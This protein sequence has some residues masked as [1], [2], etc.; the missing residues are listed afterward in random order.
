MES[1]SETPEQEGHGFQGKPSSSC[2]TLLDPDSMLPRLGKR[3]PH[4]VLANALSGCRRLDILQLNLV[5]DIPWSRLGSLWRMD[6]TPLGGSWES[7][8]VSSHNFLRFEEGGT[9][10]AIPLLAVDAGGSLG[11][12][13]ANILGCRRL[14]FNIATCHTQHWPRQA[15][16]LLTLDHVSRCRTSILATAQQVGTGWQ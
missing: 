2:L 9:R 8:S 11:A 10:S 6:W 14:C 16:Y 13:R 7:V 3:S 4:T 1:V 15:Q 12:K 5:W